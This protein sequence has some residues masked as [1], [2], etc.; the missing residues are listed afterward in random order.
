[1]IMDRTYDQ[2]QSVLVC[3]RAVI[4]PMF[5]VGSNCDMDQI[6]LSILLTPSSTGGYYA[7]VLEHDLA[8]DG[9]T[10]DATLY[11][12]V[13]V[14]NVHVASCKSL[15]R[16]PF[17]C[18]DRAPKEFF[19]LWDTGKLIEAHLPDLRLVECPELRSTVMVA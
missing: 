18:L 12:L 2:G 4:S 15:G 9:R 8:A 7:Q 6:T 16:T 13:R 1:M 10:I 17:S 3:G 19:D 14:L 5:D 11:E